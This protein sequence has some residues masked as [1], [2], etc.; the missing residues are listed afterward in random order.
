MYT[1][2]VAEDE[3]LVR[4]GLLVSIPWSQLQM[5]VV[6]EVSNGIDAWRQFQEKQP[7]II[8]TDIRM[9]G[10]DGVSFVQEIRK[11]NANCAIIVITCVEDFQTLRDMMQLGIAAY[12]VK[13]TMTHQE[14]IDAINKAVVMLSDNALKRPNK[15]KDCND[16]TEKVTEL[17]FSAQEPELYIHNID[18]IPSIL[19]DT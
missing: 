17:L 16:I 9:P 6:A 10:M 4:M 5:E 15:I 1:V 12:L 13:A 14:I 19:S 8:I 3:Y 11:T 7:D 18:K 2:L